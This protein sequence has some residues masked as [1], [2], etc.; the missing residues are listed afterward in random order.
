MNFSFAKYNIPILQT[1]DC[2]V[3]EVK[4][5]VKGCEK[6]FTKQSGYNQ[7]IVKIHGHMKL[8]KHFCAICKQVINASDIQFKEHRKQCY[9]EFSSKEQIIECEVCKKVRVLIPFNSLNVKLNFL[10]EMQNYQKL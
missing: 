9:K 2:Q 7:H 3:K 10:T 6:V 8:S 1:H 4:C 5:E